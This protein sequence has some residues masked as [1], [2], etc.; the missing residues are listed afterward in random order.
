[1]CISFIDYLPNVNSPIA[2]FSQLELHDIENLSTIYQFPKYH[3]ITKCR[4]IYIYK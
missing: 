1:M 2:L 3:N 4:D